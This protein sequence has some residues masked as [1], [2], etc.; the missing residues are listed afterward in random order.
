MFEPFGSGSDGSG[1]FTQTRFY[2][3]GTVI[4]RPCGKKIVLNSF[5]SFPAGYYSTGC[6]SSTINGVAKTRRMAKKGRVPGRTDSGKV[7]IDW[8]HGRVYSNRPLNFCCLLTIY[9]LCT[10]WLR[11]GPQLFFGARIMVG[12]KKPRLY[13]RAG[14]CPFREERAGSAGEN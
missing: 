5:I 9:N 10:I 7:R 14:G 2:P 13:A 12:R 11:L 8:S 4:P 3:V 1:G 6:G